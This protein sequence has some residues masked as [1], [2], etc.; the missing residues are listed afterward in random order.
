M[1]NI[2]FIASAFAQTFAA[3]SVAAFQFGRFL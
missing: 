3:G 2:L 1:A